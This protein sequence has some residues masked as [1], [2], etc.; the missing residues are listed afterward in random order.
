MNVYRTGKSLEILPK[1]LS[2]IPSDVVLSD[3]QN[4]RDY[5]DY[6]LNKLCSRPWPLSAITKL[7]NMFRD[8]QMTAEQ[9]RFVVDK[10][11]ELLGK[12]DVEE[13]PPLVYQLLLL[14]T[15][16]YSSSPS[17]SHSLYTHTHPLFYGGI[18]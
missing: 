18:Y 8:I 15:K 12:L 9:Y 4:G 3:G 2:L 7:A 11:I 13:L 5:K 14:S 6:F 16:V 17:H 10:M 1:L